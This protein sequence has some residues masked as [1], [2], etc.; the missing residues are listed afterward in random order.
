MRA[1]QV[2]DALFSS[3]L[4]IMAL[5]CV[6]INDRDSMAVDHVTV[7]ITSRL[8]PDKRICCTTAQPGLCGS[9]LSTSCQICNRLAVRSTDYILYS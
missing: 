3:L 7:R 4:M 2:A 5:Y 9:V 1:I 6:T 8:V